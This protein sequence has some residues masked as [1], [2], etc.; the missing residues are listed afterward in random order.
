MNKTIVSSLVLLGCSL[1]AVEQRIEIRNREAAGVGYSTGYSSL[2]YYLM[3]D[4]PVE[5]LLDLRGHVFNN[6]QGAGNAGVG[7]RCPV[8]DEKYLLGANAFYDVRQS[9]DLFAN[10]VGVGFEALNK[11]VDFRTNGYLPVGKKKDLETK[12][13]Q[14]F[15]GTHILIRRKLKSTLPCVDA[16]V[17]TPLPKPF[18]FALGGYYLF[19]QSKDDLHVGNAFGV[20]AR[21]EVDIGRYVSLG[22]AIT[23]DRI[24]KT[25]PQGYISVNIPFEKQKCKKR[26]HVCH[27]YHRNLRRVTIKR[28]EIIPIEVE[29]KKRDPLV[30]KGSDPVRILF[31]N[32]LAKAAGNGSFEKPFASLKDAENHSAPGDVIYVFPGDNTARNMDEGIVLKDNQMLASSGAPLAL[33]GVTIPAQTENRPQITNINPDQPV[34]ANPGNSRLGDFFFIPPWEYIFGRG[35]D[36]DP[37]AEAR[38][39][40][41]EIVEPNKGPSV[42]SI[43]NEFVDVRPPSADSI[44]DTFEVIPTQPQGATGHGLGRAVVIDNYGGS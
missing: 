37:F 3:T 28:N 41:F 22:F 4:G 21:A 29:K 8:D 34:V 15:S 16:E 24:F 14:T 13:F 44:I 38:D 25:R 39:L 27:T 11:Y 30:G 1:H 20:K 42:D 6:G 26:K 43:I 2:D 33:G 23:Y 10:Q 31:V 19:K 32:N 5:F 36:P 18:Y 9:K 40:G 17:G 35:I 12:R 7:F